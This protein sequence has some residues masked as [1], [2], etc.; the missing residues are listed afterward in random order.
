MNRIKFN[1]EFFSPHISGKEKKNERHKYRMEKSWLSSSTCRK[2]LGDASR[3][4]DH[5]LN[6]SNGVV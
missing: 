1:R 3:C 5:K 4:L 6:L 2:D